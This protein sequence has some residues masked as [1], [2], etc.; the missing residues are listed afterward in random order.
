MAYVAQVGFNLQ[1]CELCLAQRWPYGVAIALGIATRLV[2][3]PR[4]VGTLVLLMA[5]TFLLET[6]IALFHVGVE[7]HWWAYASRCMATNFAPIKAQEIA[8][9]LS[10]PV[11]L[12]PCDRPAFVLFGL[13]MAAYNAAFAFVLSLL[14]LTDGFSLGAAPRCAAAS[15]DALHISAGE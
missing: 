14:A 4:V 5:L 7:Q 12:A 11:R 1:P 10:H 9:L 13:S 2:S 3:S 6:S 8:E 15:S